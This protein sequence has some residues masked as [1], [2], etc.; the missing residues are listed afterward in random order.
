MLYL[1]LPFASVKQYLNV[2]Q[3]RAPS[4]PRRVPRVPC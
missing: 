4:G 3:A 2:L 1:C